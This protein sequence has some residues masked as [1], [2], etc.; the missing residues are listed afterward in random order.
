[1]HTLI[2]GYHRGR[3]FTTI[4]NEIINPAINF[5]EQRL[6]NDQEGIMKNIVDIC[7]AKSINE[8][9]VA[10]RPLLECAGIVGD[11]VKEFTDT[12]FEI[13]D[14]L[15]PNLHVLERDYTVRILYMLR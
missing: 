1:M 4:Q 11:D 12:V 15:K 7:G 2:D 6:D 5:L 9:L 14:D 10:S 8:F 3:S 13:F